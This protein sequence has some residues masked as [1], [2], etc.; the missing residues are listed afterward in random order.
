MT[1]TI[2][3]TKGTPV[4]RLDLGHQAAGYYTARS[5][6]A[7]WNGCN[8]SGESVASGVYFYQLQVRDYTA[9]R[10]MVILK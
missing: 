5:K 1:F 9:L 2:Y 3:D 7:Y 4:R 10:R 6:A 8:E